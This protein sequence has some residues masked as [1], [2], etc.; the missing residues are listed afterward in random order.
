MKKRTFLLLALIAMM[1]STLPVQAGQK[2]NLNGLLMEFISCTPYADGVVMNFTFTNTSG[3]EMAFR[4]SNFFEGQCFVID[5]DGDQ[6]QLTDLVIGKKGA[7]GS[8]SRPIPQDITM[9]GQIYF[10]HVSERHTMIKR[11]KLLCQVTKEGTGEKE[12]NVVMTDIPITPLSNTNMEGTRFTDPVVKMSTK[13]AMHLGKNIDLQFTL[14]NT[15]KD[16]YDAP[17][18]EITAYDED[19]NTY[20]GECSIRNMRLETDMP[21]KFTI[22]IKN[23]PKSVKKLSLVRAM[24]DEWGHKME[25]RNIA[26]DEAPYTT[27]ETNTRC[28]LTDVEYSQTATILHLEFTA[29]E[30][31]YMWHSKNS[32]IVGNDGKKLNPLFFLRG[33]SR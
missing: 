10:R 14:T 28:K 13:G 12:Q 21:Q 1:I 7:A 31:G 18:R 19:G 22:V 15:D 26:V 4:V 20:N 8:D 2:F 6:H 24:F 27:T 30:D 11:M 5:E 33:P 23:V 16:R 9:K 32:Y 25:W 3:R 29:G 17:V